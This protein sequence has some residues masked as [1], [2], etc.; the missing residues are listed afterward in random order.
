MPYLRWNPNISPIAIAIKEAG[1][2]LRVKPTPKSL[3]NLA[4]SMPNYG[5]GEKFTRYI[6]KH[7]GF[8]WQIT[9]VAPRTQVTDSN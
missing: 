1:K 9:S 5:V 3:F 8:Y 4:F 7:P 6:W 2:P